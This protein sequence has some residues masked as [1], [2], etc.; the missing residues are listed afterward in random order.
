MT[1]D[2]IR[3]DLDFVRVT[4]NKSE[5]H[6]VC[7]ARS[8]LGHEIKGNGLI[9]SKLASILR[10]EPPRFNGVLEI[11]REDVLSFVPMPL[12]TAFLRG[13]QPTQLLKRKKVTQ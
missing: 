2:T 7:R 5:Y 1:D 9:L 3:I 4:R 10:E 12:K 11:Y 8:S 13:P 6:T